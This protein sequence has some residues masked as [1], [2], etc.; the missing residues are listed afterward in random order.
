MCD[1]DYDPCAVFDVTTPK[2]RRPHECGE[3]YLPI[4]PGRQY[5]R[6]GMLF[7]GSWR[8]YRAHAECWALMQFIEEKVCGGHGTILLHGLG[9]EISSLG[10][11]DNAIGDADEDALAM[12]FGH[13]RWPAREVCDW[14]WDTIKAEYRPV[15][16]AGRTR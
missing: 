1:V 7:E 16:D 9:E 8:T 12:G 3:C 10:D 6:V 5:V 11:Y 4:K 13:D 2:A 15:A 14:L